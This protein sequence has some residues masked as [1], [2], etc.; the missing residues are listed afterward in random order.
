MMTVEADIDGLKRLVGSEIGT[1]R[2]VDITQTRV[3]T[4]ADVTEDRQWIHTDP[5]RAE[6]ES[7]FGGPIAHGYL[8]LS[9]LSALWDS[10]FTATG[11]SMAVNYGLNRVRFPA[12]VPVGSRVRMTATLL[13]VDDIDAG[14]QIVL[15]A[16]FESEGTNKPVC[17]AEPIFRL[18][19]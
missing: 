7:P 14:V 13:S 6:R 10:V 15:S 4:F 2:W 11:V 3:S 1:S 12:P 18:Y 5:G 19:R 16:V 8:T 9:L 17:V